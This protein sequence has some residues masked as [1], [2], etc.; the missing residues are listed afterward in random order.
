VFA[1][2]NPRLFTKLQAGTGAPLLNFGSELVLPPLTLAE[3][4]AWALPLFREGGRH[5]SEQRKTPAIALD[6]GGVSA[7]HLALEAARATLDA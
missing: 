6:N 5:I 1:G 2:S 4:D 7:K 3:I